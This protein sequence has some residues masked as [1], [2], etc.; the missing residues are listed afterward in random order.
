MKNLVPLLFMA[1]FCS[2]AVANGT[3]AKDAAFSSEEGY[4]WQKAMETMSPTYG[5][6]AHDMAVAYQAKCRESISIAQL[7]N[8]LQTD[9]AMYM[10]ALLSLIQEAHKACASDKSKCGAATGFTEYMNAA[11][12][13]SCPQ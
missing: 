11:T 13:V 6:I 8:D 9:R 7:T 5:G 4:V 3:N 12:T 2:G 10:A 1:A